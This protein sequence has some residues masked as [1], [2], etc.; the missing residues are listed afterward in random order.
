MMV[1]I[2]IWLSVGSFVIG[3]DAVAIALTFCALWSP[4]APVASVAG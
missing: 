3:L 1:I 2:H 4:S